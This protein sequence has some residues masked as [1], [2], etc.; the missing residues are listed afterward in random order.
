MRKLSPWLGLA[1][2]LGLAGCSP[3]GGRTNL[4][5]IGGGGGATPPTTEAPTAADLVGYLNTNSQAIPGI[6]SDDITL[7]CHH[8]MGLPVSLSGKLRCQGPRSFRMT[9]DFL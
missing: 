8:G 6:Q 7:T 5:R 2:L 3:D 1:V 9:G 4:I